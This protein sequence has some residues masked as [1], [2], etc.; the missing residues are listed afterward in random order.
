MGMDILIENAVVLTMDDSKPVIKGAFVGIDGGKIA[1]LDTAPPRGYP[2]KSIDGQ[3]MVVM[4]GLVNTHSHVAMSLLR[5]YADDFRLHEWLHQHVFPVEAKFDARCVK[6]GALLGMAE[7]IKSGTISITDMYFHIPAVAEAAFEAGIYAN[8]SNG[9]TCFNRAYYDFATDGVTKEMEVMLD[10]WHGCDDGRIMLD[11]A[12]HAEYT[13]FER[14]WRANAS[15]ARKNGLNMH[16]HISE[17]A[18]ENHECI[19]RYGRSPVYVLSEA[20]VFE[21]PTTAAHC[22]H[23]D[24]RDMDILASSGVTVAHN[25]ISNLKLACGIAPVKD[26]LSKGVNVSI[27]TDSVCSNNS[28]DM[29]QSLKAAA[30]LQKGSSLDP[31]AVPAYEALKMATV[32]GARAQGRQGHIGKIALGMDAS[33]IMVDA[34][35]PGL[36]PMHN[37]V[38]LMAYSAS[39]GD[40][41]MTMVKG[42]ILYI[43]GKL[44][45]IDLQHVAQELGEYVMP[46][47][48]GA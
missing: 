46:K 21:T 40:V 8:I 3:G 35:R 13:S 34:R 42:K 15:F 14:L 23:V 32:N 7:M 39:G 30:L 26:M 31:T 12:I 19:R 44:T 41:Y 17:T 27:G 4:P 22:V 1:H 38:S 37:P 9:A 43:D 10:V 24:D 28:H 16:V 11:A 5:G 29:F 45:T 20:G 33:L 18:E 47:V 48:F 2:E 6:A 36:M 25:P